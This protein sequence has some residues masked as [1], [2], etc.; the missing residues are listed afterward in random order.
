MGR[1]F[2]ANER[3]GSAGFAVILVFVLVGAVRQ[4]G[5]SASDWSTTADAGEEEQGGSQEAKHGVRGGSGSRLG[6]ATRSLYVSPA[7][8]RFSKHVGAHSLAFHVSE[9]RGFQRRRGV[10]N[11]CTDGDRPEGYDA[12]PAREAC[13]AFPLRDDADYGRNSCCSE[14]PLPSVHPECSR[15]FPSIYRPRMTSTRVS[16]YCG[17]TH[18]PLDSMSG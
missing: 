4:L 11:S 6:S 13:P 14:A 3:L 9:S 18:N 8:Y 15:L 17:G 7:P 2:E 10:E 1:L 5:S 12:T 16:R